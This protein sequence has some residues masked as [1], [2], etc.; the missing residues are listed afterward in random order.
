MIK[1]SDFQFHQDGLLRDYSCTIACTVDSSIFPEKLFFSGITNELPKH[2]ATSANFALIGL[3]Y[4]AMVLGEDLEIEAAVSPILLYSA[5][6]D[7]QSLLIDYRPD[8]KRIKVTATAVTSPPDP[9]PTNVATGFSAGVDTFTTLA[10]F[11]ANDVPASRRITSLTTFDCGAMGPYEQTLGIFEKYSQRVRNYAEDNNFKWQTVRSNIDQFYE[12]VDQGFQLTHV[13]RNAATALIF[14]DIFSTYLC[15]STYPYRSIN[16]KN[17]DMSYIEPILLPLLSTE[18]LQFVS[19]GAGLARH[20]KTQLIST[21]PP[22]MQMLDVCVAPADKRLSNQKINCCKCWKCSRMMLNLDLLGRLDDFSEVF[23]IN[24]YH[25]NKARLMLSVY[26]SAQQ[27]KPADR[28]LINLMKGM[29]RKL[30][31]SKCSIIKVKFN[32]LTIRIR[33]YMS[34]FSLLRRIYRYASPVIK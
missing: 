14:E 12:A 24:Y 3:L 30:E 6:Q 11:T 13:V 2:I 1:A 28:D 20:Q 17:D 8:L 33:Q 21:Y 4:P 34:K 26:E 7:I 16:S 31:I 19:A 32:F 9:P 5:Q 15:S 18:T 10:L 27:G 29:G 22:A 23:D 25:R